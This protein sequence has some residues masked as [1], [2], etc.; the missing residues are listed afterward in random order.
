MRST[1]DAGVV[2]EGGDRTNLV[3]GGHVLE[4]SRVSGT[5]Y[6]V[7]ANTPNVFMG[8]V[9]QRVERSELSHSTHQ[10]IW[11]QGNDHTIA[12]NDIHDV[13]QQTQD[14]TRE[15]AIV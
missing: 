14:S 10:A 9:G 11:L 8:G 5:N 12:Q 13:V 4:D 1:G 7:W 3:P 6:F 2:L 15:R